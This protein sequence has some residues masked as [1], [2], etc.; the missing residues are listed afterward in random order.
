MVP[1]HELKH[2]LTDKGIGTPFIRH[3]G[4]SSS[5]SKREFEANSFAIKAI[6]RSKSNEFEH[7]NKYQ[8]CESLDLSNDWVKY[9]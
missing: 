5:I 4:V 3:F 6:V 9:F 2:C 8:I 1:L 7:M